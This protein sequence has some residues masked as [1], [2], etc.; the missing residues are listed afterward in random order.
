[1]LHHF[2]FRP[3]FLELILGLCAGLLLF[4][5][6][7]HAGGYLRRMARRKALWIVVSALLGP[8]VRLALLPLAAVPVPVIHDE[9]VHLL[10]AD[11]LRQG[12]V[13]NPPHP[14]S[15]HFET[16]YVLQKPAYAASYPLGIGAS[17]ALGWILTGQPWFG[18][19]LSMVLCC[20]AVAWLQYRWNAPL[21]ALT[22]SL[23]FSLV[24]GISSQWI[25]TYWGGAVAGAGGALVFGA[26]P[27]LWQTA[28][29]RYAVILGAGWTLMWFVRPYESAIVGLVIAACVLRKKLWPAA[30][31]LG[32]VVAL[33]LAGTCYHNWRVTGDPLTLPYQ[34]TQKRYGVPQGFIWQ[35]EIPAPES[36]NPQQMAAYEW[37]RDSFRVAQSF[38]S[39]YLNFK[40]VW[41]FYLGY[42]LTIPLLFALFA[43]RK[44]GTQIMFWLTGICLAW[45]L[46]YWQLVP[47]YLAAIAGL[48]MALVSRGLVRMAHWRVRSVPVGAY[49]AGALWIASALSGLRIMYPWI[50]RG[51]PDALPARAVIA[52]QLASSRERHLVFVRFGPHDD[53]HVPWIYNDAAIDEA[54]VVWANDLGLERNEQLVRYFANRRVWLVEPDGDSKLKA[55]TG[56]QTR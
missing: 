51:G 38:I 32:A 9:F 17:L 16:I 54:K 18:V 7:V 6:R 56:I 22:G 50:L 3:E 53:V 26:L 27:G 23:L 37:Q 42:P 55:Y 24:F 34:L 28:R 30:A 13:A 46:L 39:R 40:R 35:K 8:S 1:M 29:L 21:A 36:V 31:V 20:G 48:L 47:H 10:A 52:G 11:T 4:V 2:P 43:D 45:S 19:W 15:D 12:R 33:D 44:R 25:N 41:A 49:L 14:F 5:F